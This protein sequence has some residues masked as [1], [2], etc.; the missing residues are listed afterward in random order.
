MKISRL[1]I[2]FVISLL[3]IALAI[4]CLSSCSIDTVNIP[5]KV[6]RQAIREA[7]GKQIGWLN[8]SD[9]ASITS[10]RVIPQ[11]KAVFG[12]KEYVTDLRGLEYCTNLQ[13]LDIS[14]NPVQDIS[15]LAEL[16][17][18]EILNLDST[19][20]TDLSSLQN[21]HLKELSLQSIHISDLSPLANMTSLEFLYLVSDD[22]SAL[23]SLQNLR[24]LQ[25]L[26]LAGYGFSDI[27][28]VANFQEL[29]TLSFANTT[30]VDISPLTALA[31]L[32]QLSILEDP[33]Q[34]GITDFSPLAKLTNLEM[35]WLECNQ[36][37][38]ISSLSSLIN[39]TDVYLSW[40]SD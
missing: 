12:R 36:L 25:T 21:L 8:I 23:S 20:V 16:N 7:V 11:A 24:H 39:L 4:G 38:D 26:R 34:P 19:S 30:V 32:R 33:A 18:L 9:L 28:L 14:Q 6:L 5:D 3:L 31:A 2:K 13:S 15:P 27:S 35:L 1:W 29:T 22:S 40:K 17:S 10:L 37:K